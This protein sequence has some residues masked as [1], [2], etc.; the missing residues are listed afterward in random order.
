[1]KC[2]VNY[3]WLLNILM[4]CTNIP[5]LTQQCYHSETKLYHKYGHQCTSITQQ[6]NYTIYDR[7]A[8][9]FFEICKLLDFMQSIMISPYRRFRTAYQTHLQ[10]ESSQAV[11][12]VSE[13][14]V[15][16]VVL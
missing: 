10:G 4:S 1:M 7:C 13:T 3:K 15:N 6:P 2:F 9:I 8:Y 5:S 11:Y 12:A 14:K 16:L